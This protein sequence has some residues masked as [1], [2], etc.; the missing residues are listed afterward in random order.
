[1]PEEQRSGGILF[2]QSKKN[3][4]SITSGLKSLHRKLKNSWKVSTLKDDITPEKLKG[5]QV[6]FIVAPKQKF[7]SGECAAI[8]AF[9][10]D[11]GSVFLM[12]GEGGETKLDTNVNFLL[13][14]YG[15]I[16]NNDAVIRTA[17]HKYHHP[18]ECLVTNG[19]LNREINNAAGKRVVEE[20]PI[21]GVQYIYPFGATLKV[22]KPAVPLLS[23]GCVS[24]PLS[25][26]T[27]ALATIKNAKKGKLLVVGSY[28]MFSDSYLDKEDNSRLFDVLLQLITTNTIQLNSLDADN[29]DIPDN[30]TLPDTGKLAEQLRVCLQEGDEVPRDFTTLADK[31]LFGITTSAIPAA[32]RAYDE[33]HVKHEQLTLITPQFETPL[34][35]LLPA[36]FPPVFREP[37]GPALDLF[38]LDDCFS[39]ERVRLA[40]LTNKCNDDDLEY[41]VR[42]C[43]DI[44]GIK[45]KPDGAQFNAKHVLEVV[46]REMVAFKKFNQD[47]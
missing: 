27:C 35:P 7:T 9:L 5:F 42:E 4:L 25:Q 23:T 40:Q 31:T 37:D 6:F 33:L 24:L 44:F 20:S 47:K 3:V 18:K 17:Y 36:V 38:D 28:Q 41:F 1:M 30:I 21:H 46:L 15:V 16:V 19:V 10:E 12:L 11:G 22:Q 39:S 8:K 45:P 2:D 32:V 14:E 13:E 43:G 34:P 26:P 29:P